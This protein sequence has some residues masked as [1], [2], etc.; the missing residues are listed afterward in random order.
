MKTRAKAPSKEA[1]EAPISGP[2]LR[3]SDQNPGKLV[4]L[5]K[6][7]SQEARLVILHDPA[8]KKPTRYVFCPENGF[9]EFTRISALSNSPRSWLIVHDQVKAKSTKDVTHCDPTPSGGQS[10]KPD[11]Y[12]A[13]ANDM[14]VATPFDALFFLLPALH[15]KSKSPEHK[16]YLALDDLVDEVGSNS[17]FL[18]MS[19]QSTMIRNA[20]EERLCSVCDT[21]DAGDE[22]MFRLSREELVQDLIK[23]AQHMSKDGLPISMENR[24]VTE[25]LETPIMN[26]S[27]D[28]SRAETTL[29]NDPIEAPQTTE[30]YNNK[31][32]KAV[33]TND[34][35]TRI[36]RLRVAL[37]FMLKSYLPAALRHEVE[38]LLAS[39][40]QLNLIGLEEHLNHLASVRSEA[41][42]LRSISDN[43]NR[44]R[45]MNDDD[46]EAADARAEK[47][48]RQEEKDR[49]KKTESQGIKQLKKVDTSGMKKLS[50]FFSKAAPK[51]AA[52]G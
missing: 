13:A 52:S 3:P 5:P 40:E 2:V 49:L 21:V 34:E 39:N 47:K 20:L 1:Q 11:D 9:Y 19:L 15:E 48:R 8:I 6:G 32:P 31:L 16:L 46:D 4:I 38:S 29:S 43:I 28:D 44:K 51:K 37:S 50:S 26:E 42:A 25:A 22:R 23:R 12:I 41:L 7:L 45:L 30:G 10:S 27:R 36:L 17:K 24:F 35:L 18:R 33:M 14:L